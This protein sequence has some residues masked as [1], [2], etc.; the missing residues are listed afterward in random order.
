M[1]CADVT[2]IHS[3][4]MIYNERDLLEL[5]SLFYIDI[6]HW[7]KK[8]FSTNLIHIFGQLLF[9]KRKVDKIMFILWV[10]EKAQ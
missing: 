10:I 6:I 1:P 2:R 3:S 8:Q 5:R 4:L 9:L 7:I